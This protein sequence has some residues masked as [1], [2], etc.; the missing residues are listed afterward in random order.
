MSAQLSELDQLDGQAANDLTQVQI[1][2]APASAR[3]SLR[4]STLGP[5]ASVGEFRP[6]RDGDSE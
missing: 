1:N 5:N 6:V 3:I 4:Q 2:S